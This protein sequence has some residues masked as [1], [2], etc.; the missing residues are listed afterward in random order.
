MLVH[1]RNKRTITL[2]HPRFANTMADANPAGPAPTTTAV[3]ETPAEHTIL[4]ALSVRS[5]A[6]PASVL[7]DKHDGPPRNFLAHREPDV[8]DIIM[9]G[10]SCGQRHVEINQAR[11]RASRVHWFLYLPVQRY[12]VACIDR[13]FPWNR[14]FHGPCASVPPQS[15]PGWRD[16]CVHM[17][18]RTVPT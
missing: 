5:I 7:R 16:Q 10:W 14:D 6:R 1:D 2:S 18:V 17:Y 8:W 15:W 11:L 12:R 9:F 13:D 4:H 3:L